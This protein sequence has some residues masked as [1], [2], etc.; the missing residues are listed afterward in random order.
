VYTLVSA[1][2]LGF[3]LVRM[4]GGAATAELLLSAL[5]LS[6]EDLP[7]LAAP[8]PN[9]SVRAELW[10]EVAAAAMR[11]RRTADL[12][13]LDAEAATALLLR[14][15]I[16]SLDGLLHCLRHDVLDWL[17]A[18]RRPGPV[19]EHEHHGGGAAGQVPDDDL[20]PDFEHD[21]TG[22][23]VA[24]LCDVAA[25]CYLRAELPDTARRRL[26]AG[27]V[28]ASRRIPARP[29]DLGPQHRSVSRIL[30]RVRLLTPTRAAR[31]LSTT[32]NARK[33]RADWAAAMHSASWAVYLSGRVRAAAA[34]QLALVSAVDAAGVPVADRAAGVWNALSG[35]IHALIVRDVSDHQTTHRLLEPYLTA[36]GPAGLD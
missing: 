3:D 7:A 16:G 1:P 17:P 23:A 19:A 36:F 26:S 28:V 22:D 32:E 12:F 24:V 11:Q 8:L 27:W 10:L 9:P 35:V 2:V 15:P 6:A 30:D 14:S 4:E 20:A 5:M 31:L 34:A 13:G 18:P 21:P 25:A 29:A 33:E